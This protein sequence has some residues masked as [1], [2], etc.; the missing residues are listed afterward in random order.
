MLSN[1]RIILGTDT[2]Q[3]TARIVSPLP[4]EIFA[5]EDDNF[6]IEL[7]FDN[8]EMIADLELFFEVNGEISNA[9]SVY[10]DQFVNVPKNNYYE[11]LNDQITGDFIENINIYI[12]IIDVAGSTVNDHPSGEYHNEMGPLTFSRN[13]ITIDFETGWHLLAPPLEGQNILS[14]IFEEDA[15]ECTINGCILIETAN[16]GT[17]FYV[18]NYGENQN[19]T[20]NGEVLAQFSSTLDQ[21]WNLTGNPL[22]NSVDIN[23]IIITYNNTDYN[24]LDAAKY[25]II[26][27]TPIIYDNV[28]GG[29]IGTSEL[30]TA[31]GFWVHSFY[32]NVGI[33]F[34]PSNPVQEVEASNYWNLSLF[35]KENNVGANSDESIGSEI[36]IG[37]HEN[38]NNTIVNGEDQEVFPLSSISS[39]IFLGHYNELIINSNG[40]S[41]SRDIRSYHEP[42]ITWD[43][44][45]ESVQPFNTDQ[46]V[47][48]KWEFSG[49]ND[50]YDYFLD[51]GDGTP[52]NMKEVSSAVASHNHFLEEMSIRAELKEEYI[53]CTH[54]LADNYN[55]LPNGEY[56]T[57]GTCLGG[58]QAEFCEILSLALPETFSIDPDLPDQA[59]ELPISL[60]NPQSVAIEGLQ[61]ILEYDAEMIQLNEVT[62]NEN[63]GGYIIE[64]DIC[65]NCIPAELSVIVYYNG[66]GELISGEGEIL[67]LS[68]NGLENTG[69]TTISFSSVQI[70][71]NANAFG[72]SCDISIG[73][74]YLSVSGEIIYYYNG[75]SV[76]GGFISITEIDNP[77]NI[78]GTISNEDGNFIVES[79]V[80]D[81]TYELLLAKD[82]YGG[83]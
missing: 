75:I 68:G 44:E 6:L 53:G 81:K 58:N 65:A 5:L 67:T 11:F 7:E 29:H 28:N 83:L 9:I 63:L 77:S 64:Q 4:N 26:S 13:E 2:V 12:E 37:I 49:N 18:R 16:S 42:S 39:N 32:D 69:I 41:L 60:A 62:L 3:P 17:G 76:S 23:S 52:V 40:S 1:F 22:V 10:V 20:F 33:S 31:V 79:I 55:E 34:I 43:L 59:F 19:F 82:E 30:S 50:P 51:I 71:E 21:G 73:I 24:W 70:N 36:V 56:C 38:A 80:G 74:T 48:F 78:N 72:N 14:E 35:A 47:I 57:N 15:S 25:G 8:P 54:P 61:F 66:L 45:G 27:P 46:G